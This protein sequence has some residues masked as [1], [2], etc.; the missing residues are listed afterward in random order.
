MLKLPT[1]DEVLNKSI[2]IFREEFDDEPNIHVCAPGRVNLI[3]EHVDYCNGFV[4]PMALPYVT[5]IVGRERIGGIARIIT[6]CDGVNEERKTEFS[7]K[8]IKP[9]SLK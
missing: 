5:M 3:G 7:T 4:L 9:G 2:K 6:C 1:F 8:N